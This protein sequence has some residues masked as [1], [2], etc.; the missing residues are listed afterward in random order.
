MTAHEDTWSIGNQHYLVAALA[1]VRARLEQHAAQVSAAA[2]QDMPPCP[3]EGAEDGGS[4][5]MAPPALEQLCSMFHL[6]AFERSIL[7]LCAGVD[8][9]STFAGLCAAA[10]GDPTRS[11]PTFSLALAA[12]PDAHWSAL[13]PEAPLR[14]WRLIEVVQAPASGLVARPLRIDE[15]VLHFLAGIQELDERLVGL[16]E[17][18]SRPQELVPSH[19][20]L[21]ER[22]AAAW[23]RGSGSLPVIQLC[24]ADETSRRAIAAA[25]C[26]AVGLHLF[27]LPAEVVPSHAAELEALARLWERE[28]ALTASALYI[29]AEVADR[30]DVRLG[31]PIS[32]LLERLNSGLVLGSS[33]RWRPLRRA[34]LTLDV[35][36]PTAQE[37]R[38]LW[39]TALGD[40]NVHLNGHIHGLVS[41]FNLGPAAIH[42]AVHEALSSSVDGAV[43]ATELWNA[44]RAQSRPRLDDLAQRIQ[45]VATWDD[46][47]L[48][49]AERRT[50]AEVAAHV[51]HRATVYETWGFGAMSSRG[52][53]I[54]ALF[55]GA[56]GTGKTMAAEVLANHLRLDLY[57]IDLS[58]V[59]SKY[60]GE[61]EKNL[62]R[63]FDAAEDGGAI[64]F[65]DEADAL[66]GKRS[67]VRD[68]HDRYANIEIN[69]L[70]QRMEQYRGLAVLATNMKG[71][72]DSA[73]M[74]RIRFMVHFP[75]PD[76]AQR[77]QIWQRIFPLGAPTEGLDLGKLARLN[78]TGGNIRNI[79][80]NAAFLAAAEG[81]PV[82]MSHLRHSTR[83]EYAKLD[84]PLTEA[85]LG[86][87]T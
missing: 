65:F 27:C 32:R 56:S 9:D 22:I 14:R 41:Q 8:L 87:W 81:T 69:Y 50:L 53:G 15:R 24:G 49:E 62:R 10:Q 45:P 77:A 16:I 57:R 74:R 76:T 42:A 86:G 6:S 78:I 28:A 13:T 23:T 37:Q 11:Y 25:G 17:P 48:P 31:T 67:E 59:V 29:E 1:E 61:T 83:N 58:A 46:L 80:L 43:L 54:S 52:L 47:V 2:A 5:L 33:E 85:E 44:G 51:A 63:V 18:V 12:F 21:A 79:A 20:A 82:R 4:Q 66:F 38:A 34:M 19:A 35:Y 3:R 84:K 39:Q 71:A 72:L 26:A 7:L 40:A 30:T 73:F 70:L 36:K 64:L 60:I 55:A 68:S 75:F